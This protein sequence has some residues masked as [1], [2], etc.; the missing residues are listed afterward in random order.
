MALARRA[1]APVQQN[2]VSFKLDQFTSGFGVAN[3]DY[4][5]KSSRIGTFEYGGAAAGTVTLA[6]KQKLQPVLI[7]GNKWEE[8]G[9]EAE[10]NWSI[11]DPTKFSADETETKIVAIGTTEKLGSGSNFFLY[12]Q[13]A[14]GAGYEDFDNDSTAFE[15]ML[16]HIDNIPEP[17]RSNMRQSSVN[18][19]QQQKRQDRTVPVISW[20][21]KLPG[22]K[23]IT[24]PRTGVSAAAPKPVAAPKPNGKAAPEP[25]EEAAGG[26]SA[27]GVLTGYLETVLKGNKSIAKTQVRVAVFKAAQAAKLEAG[28]REAV[29]AVFADDE[30]LGNVLGALNFAIDGANIVSM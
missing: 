22:E 13:N 30:A 1:A 14:H 18:P 10:Q 8:D 21:Y 17:D 5:I 11:G 24:N 20:I 2:F 29:M 12:L 7:K 27:E 19:Q 15:D 6:L 25:T 26:E 4:L 3:G 16:V 23:T 28:D 9:A